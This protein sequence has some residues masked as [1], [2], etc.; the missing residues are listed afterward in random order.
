MSLDPVSIEARPGTKRL[1]A[2]FTPEVNQLFHVVFLSIVVLQLQK[3]LKLNVARFTLEPF[4]VCVLVVRQVVNQQT[5]NFALLSVVVT[6]RVHCFLNKRNENSIL[7]TEYW[8]KGSWNSSQT[9]T[10]VVRFDNTFTSR[11]VRGQLMLPFISYGLKNEA[12]RGSIP[13]EFST[14]GP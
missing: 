11:S 10:Y 4:Q 2:L 14:R 1:P 7:T 12:D 6:S 8:L 3:C 13:W 5:A 9:W